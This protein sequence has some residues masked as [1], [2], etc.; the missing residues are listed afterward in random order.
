VAG[1]AGTLETVNFEPSSKVTP[2]DLLFTIEDEKYVAA[3]DAAAAS[4]ASAK[5][6]LLR[7]ETEL[8]R[9]E[10]ASKSRAVSEID[11][12]RAKADRDMAIAAV[13]SAEAALA[14]AELTLSYT[15]VT[16][17]IQG[18]VNRNLVDAGNLVGQ[19]GQTL[20]TRVNKMQP[21]YVYFNVPESIVLRILAEQNSK[22]LGDMRAEQESAEACVAVATDEGFPHKGEVDYIDN[23]VDTDTGT[24]QMRI[25]LDNKKLALFPGLFV[26]VKLTGA[27]IPDAVLISEK[28]V[29]SD[30][31]G[32]Y[33][34][35]VGADNMVEQRYV[36]LGAVQADGLVHI[37][38]GLEGQETV[39]VNGLMFA[40]PGL[41]VTPLTAE[42]FEAMGQ[43]AGAAKSAQ[44]K[45]DD[46]EAATQEA[47]ED[48]TLKVKKAQ[49][50]G[51]E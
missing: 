36:E 27:E 37:K 15:Q 1:V 32:K 17:P 24:I 29:G 46:Q 22:K 9:V 35:L 28:A 6:D 5:A 47:E 11:V 23:E 34:L 49:E 33:V 38:K 7:A 31:G 41:P 48:E 18:V 40:R 8:K 16:S 3:R 14:D 21:I 26:R 45:A 2:G 20:L 4:V 30:L 12:D 39:I 13:G 43:A 44:K 25:R 10:K 50:S 51:Q 19:S 42:Q